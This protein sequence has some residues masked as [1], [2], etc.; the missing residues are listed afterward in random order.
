MT[1]VEQAPYS[2]RANRL[3][4]AGIVIILLAAGAALLP[5]FWR[6]AGSAVVGAMLLAAGIVEFIAGTQRRQVT[7]LAKAAGAVTVLAGLLFVLDP[8][9]HLARIVNIVIGWLVLRSIILFITARRTG[10]SVR[11]WTTISAATDFALAAILAA[12]LSI[13]TLI[14]LLFGPTPQLVAS[15]AWV[16]ALSFVLNGLLQLEIAGCERDSV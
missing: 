12:G 5:F 1:E 14:V 9:A 13:G 10:G 7:M 15:F 16:L 8:V 6:S 4:L 2:T 11:T 3:R